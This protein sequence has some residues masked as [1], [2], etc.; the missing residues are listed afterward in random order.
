MSKFEQ[1]KKVA[2]ESV[3]KAS[4]ITE[5]FRKRGFKSFLKSD[6]SPVTLADYASQIFIISNIKKQFPEDEIIAEEENGDYINREEQILIKK[7]FDELGL[8]TLENLKEVI[9]YRGNLS[10]R[11][12]TIDPIDGTAGYQEKLTYAVGVGFMS[13]SIPKISAIAV[14]NYNQGLLALFS[15]EE[16]QGTK[17]SLGGN[18][19]KPVKISQ[20]EDI[21]KVR[22]CHSLHYDKPWVLEFAKKIGIK[23]FIQID[24]MAKFCM[25]ADGSADLYI[26]PLEARNSFSWDF[27]PGDLIVKEAG[28][29]VTDLNGKSLKFKQNKCLWTA[30][31]I[32]ASNRFLQKKI[33]NLFN[34]EIN[35]N[36]YII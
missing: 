36:M 14:P 16:N 20:V 32:F 27:M 4:E 21:Q 2:I 13:K 15:A 23:N 9:K 12:W 24:S 17:V 10:A 7:C 29:E 5:W 30:P 25:V 11:Q 34:N 3:H 6:N 35:L 1:E 26:K 22:L 33:L 18:A 19:F 28:G 8:E 31:G